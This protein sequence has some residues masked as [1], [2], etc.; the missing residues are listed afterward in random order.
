LT[1]HLLAVVEETM[2]PSQVS[3]W[4]VRPLR[5]SNSGIEQV[6]TATDVAPGPKPSPLSDLFAAPEKPTS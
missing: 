4:L 1:G 2:Q 5:L 6:A 3:L